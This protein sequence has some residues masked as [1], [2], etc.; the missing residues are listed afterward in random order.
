MDLLSWKRV[1]IDDLGR[2]SKFVAD[3]WF[4]KYCNKRSFWI[5]RFVCNILFVKWTKLHTLL[6]I[7]FLTKKWHHIFFRILYLPWILRT[8]NLKNLIFG[9]SRFHKFR[10]FFGFFEFRNFFQI[11]RSC[12]F[13]SFFIFVFLIF[14]F[15]FF[16]FFHFRIFSAPSFL[17]FQFSHLNNL[18]LHLQ[19]KHNSH[20]LII[21]PNLTSSFIW[22]FPKKMR[23][24][25][26]PNS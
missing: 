10:K 7:P 18:S 22:L 12:S 13:F 20:H 15:V 19:E 17:L 21:F 4:L 16:Q 26:N 11:L 14:A 5:F 3:F 23:W 8:W 1:P 2:G 9:C 24:G 25:N 6:L